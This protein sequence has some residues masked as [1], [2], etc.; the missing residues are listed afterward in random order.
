MGLGGWPYAGAGAGGRGQGAGGRGAGGRGRGRGQ[1]KLTLPH[2]LVRSA[3]ASSAHANG[4]RRSRKFK[5]FRVEDL[6]LR[7]S[8]FRGLGVWFRGL[9]V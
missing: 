2:C 6:G 7:G 8:G 3:G 4:Q 1:G 9:G 5:G